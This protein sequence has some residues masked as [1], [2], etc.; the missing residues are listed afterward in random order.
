MN[1]LLI[2]PAPELFCNASILANGAVTIT[3]FYIHTGGLTLTNVSVSYCFGNN[4]IPI[5]IPLIS[6]D[7]TSVTIPDLKAGF[8]YTFNVTAV[9]VKDHQAQC[10]TGLTTPELGNFNYNVVP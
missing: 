9:T 7:T 6:V 5:P 3:W 8:E 1:S 4:N 10:V 2:F